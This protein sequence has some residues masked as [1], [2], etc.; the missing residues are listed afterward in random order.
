MGFERYF[1][2]YGRQFWIPSELNEEVYV[3]SEFQPFSLIESAM[4]EDIDNILEANWNN[5]SVIIRALE[6]LVLNSSV[7]IDEHLYTKLC[8]DFLY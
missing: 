6:L 5:P 8:V 4:K 3:P 2:N 1:K 7:K